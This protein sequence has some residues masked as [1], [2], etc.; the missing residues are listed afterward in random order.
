MEHITRSSFD[1]QLMN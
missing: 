1:S